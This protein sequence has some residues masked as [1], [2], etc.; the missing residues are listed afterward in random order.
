MK[1]LILSCNTGQGHNT[2]GKAILECLNE[3]G[4]PCEMVDTLSIAGDKAS[5]TISDIYVNITTKSPVVFQ[6][7]YKAGEFI[8]TDRFKSVIYQANKVYAGTLGEYIQSNGFDTIIMPHLFPAEALTYLRKSRGLPVSCFAIA[9][10]YTCIPF[11]EET[12]MDYYFIPHADTAEEFIQKGIPAEKLIHTGIPVSK[13]FCER[14][15]KA[16]A[17]KELNLLHTGFYYLI[18]TGSMGFGKV[19]LLTETLLRQ[20]TDNDQVIILGGSNEKLKVTLRE[21]FAGDNRVLV[22]DYTDQVPLYMDACDVLFTKPGG[23]TS[24]EAAVKNIPIIHTEPIP[25]CE[26]INADFFA[27]HGLSISCKNEEEMVSA[28]VRLA[29]EPDLQQQMLS[30]QR[31]EIN[32]RAGEDICDFILQH[33]ANAK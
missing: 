16:K 20:C 11:W 33:S 28:A 18:M 31:R 17:R 23:L 21:Q 2:A 30:A 24:T 9:T 3:R 4:I 10:D 13:K 29:K 6:M 15:E 5:Q 27:S 12:E 14:M 22:L 19:Q 1:A 7:L 25:G 8:S 26:T 32:P